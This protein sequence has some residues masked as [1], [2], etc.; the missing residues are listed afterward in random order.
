MYFHIK[1]TVLR[2]YFVLKYTYSRRQKRYSTRLAGGQSFGEGSRTFKTLLREMPKLARLYSVFK[3][4]PF[5]G[6]M[7]IFFLNDFQGS[8][9]SL[10]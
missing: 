5:P 6:K 4:V 3:D 8:V 7:D 2:S 9:A 1:L 10:M